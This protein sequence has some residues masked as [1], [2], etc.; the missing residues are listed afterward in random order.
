MVKEMFRWIAEKKRKEK[1][2]KEKK[3]KETCKNYMGYASFN[4]LI[5]LPSGR[6]VWRHF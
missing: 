4:T 3:R 6:G 1:K 5:D 2:R